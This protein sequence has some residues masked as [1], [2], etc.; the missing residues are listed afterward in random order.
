MESSKGALF[1]NI[2]D[3]NASFNL[4]NAH[5]LIYVKVN[6]LKITTVNEPYK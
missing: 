4:F 6:I 5:L 2:S 3:S 1:C